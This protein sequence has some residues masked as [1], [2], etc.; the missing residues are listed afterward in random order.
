MTSKMH[1]YI[2]N[3]VA[4]IHRAADSG[5]PGPVTWADDML[6]TCVEVLARKVDEQA[7]QGDDM[8]NYQREILTELQKQVG[9]VTA[10]AQ[11]QADIIMAQARQ[12]AEH[13]ERINALEERIAVLERWTG[14]ADDDDDKLPE[15]DEA[16]IDYFIANFIVSEDVRRTHDAAAGRH[17]YG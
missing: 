17:G 4:S 7:G 1:E 15:D 8:N 6:A 2:S 12:L 11:E 13:K 14:V 10:R 16:A 3:K 9:L 5:N